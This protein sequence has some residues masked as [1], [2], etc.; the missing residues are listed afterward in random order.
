MYSKFVRDN[1]TKRPVNLF[2]ITKVRDRE[3]E[4]KPIITI[5][6]NFSVRYIEFFEKE[7]CQDRE[8]SL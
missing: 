6:T 2:E 8:S 7:D 1:E 3:K 4:T 5:G